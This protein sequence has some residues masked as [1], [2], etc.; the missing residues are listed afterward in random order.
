M[1]DRIIQ[2]SPSCPALILGLGTPS[3]VPMAHANAPSKAFA[4]LVFLSQFD[5][6]VVWV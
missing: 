4:F 3:Y 5:T 2:R 6:V 1:E